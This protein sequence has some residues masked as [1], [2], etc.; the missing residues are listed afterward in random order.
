MSMNPSRLKRSLPY[1][2]AGLMTLTGCG[3]IKEKFSRATPTPVPTVSPTPKSTP[4][5]TPFPVE[6]IWNK[7]PLTNAMYTFLKEH[8]VEGDKYLP[9]NLT[10]E[11][12]LAEKGVWAERLTYP[13]RNATGELKNPYEAGFNWVSAGYNSD[14]GVSVT[15]TRIKG[16]DELVLDPFATPSASPSLTATPTP[17]PSSSP[18]PFP[19]PTSTPTSTPTPTP[20]STPTPIPTPEPTV[21]IPTPSMK[22]AGDAIY[23]VK[24]E[25]EPQDSREGCKVQAF[26]Y[27]DIHGNSLGGMSNNVPFSARSYNASDALKAHSQL[28]MFAAIKG[29]VDGQALYKKANSATPNPSPSPSPSSSP[30]A[31][32][33]SSTPTPV[34]ELYRE[35]LYQALCGLAGKD[36]EGAERFEGDIFFPQKNLEFEVMGVFA[37]SKKENLEDHFSSEGADSRGAIPPPLN[38]RP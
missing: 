17:S 33:P 3:K 31:P 21:A 7:E 13:F 24:I 23:V 14:A 2:L 1:V 28:L 26:F 12:L 15:V 27:F 37:P 38:E 10:A 25:G 19:S 20:T 16:L 32:S 6:Y 9:G 22:K 18:S 30:A 8:A 34:V 29:P 36:L 11:T 4:I 5:P 35:G